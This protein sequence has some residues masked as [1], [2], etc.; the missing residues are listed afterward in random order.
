MNLP[1][2]FD[3]G[4]RSGAAALLIT[5]GAL[6]AWLPAWRVSRADPWHVLREQ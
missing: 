2:R 3:G 6:A 5:V 4:R 1:F